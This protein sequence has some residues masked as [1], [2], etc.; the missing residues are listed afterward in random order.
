MASEYRTGSS[1]PVVRAYS[2][3]GMAHEAAGNGAFSSLADLGRFLLDL[4]AMSIDLIDRNPEWSGAGD[5]IRIGT[6]VALSERAPR[7][8]RVTQLS[9]PIEAMDLGYFAYACVPVRMPD[10]LVMG[11]LCGLGLEPRDLNARE[12]ETMQRLAEL[13]GERLSEQPMQ[14]N[15]AGLALGQPV[16]G[17]TTP[18]HVQ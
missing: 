18:S 6:S 10:G 2:E 13:V 3:S 14:P 5:A 16:A 1:E 17:R 4:D 11:K 7:P 8:Q 9:D 12:I 15:A